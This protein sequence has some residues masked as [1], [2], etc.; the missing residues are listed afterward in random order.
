MKKTF[1][2]NEIFYSL[3]GEG[4]W[5]GVPMIFIRFSGCNLSCSWCDTNHKEG[6]DLTID[7]IE[8]IISQY[9]CN[10]LCLTGGE[11]LLQVTA[12]FYSY[13]CKYSI[14]IETNGTFPI[15]SGDKS[16]WITVSPKQNWVQKEGDELKVIWN[17][18]TK[19]ELCEYFAGTHFK[20]YYLQPEYSYLHV[21]VLSPLHESRLKQLL[22]TIK[23]DS[24]WNLSL[25][26]QKILNIQ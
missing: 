3:Q 22:Q 25:Q 14:H 8:S 10:R 17:D 4:H 13:F 24:R 6:T 16:C 11:P 23:E 9:P 18:Q 2:I 1:R 7:Q 12:S 26:T 5:T 19:E 20:Y 21:P 15:F